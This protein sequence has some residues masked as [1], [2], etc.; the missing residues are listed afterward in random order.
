MDNDKL[1]Q[2]IS[3]MMVQKLNEQLAPVTDRLDK[4]ES[5]VS[6]LKTGQN[7]RFDKIESEVS[8][9]KT[10]Q[11]NRLDKIESEISAL[12][13]GQIELKKELREVRHKV[14]DTYEL[15]LDAW[16]QSTENRHWIEDSTG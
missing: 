7:D 5:E 12:R 2:A 1:L 9:L 14:S 11:N 13:I 8:A 3:D 15:A 10:G 16:G 6:V 4:I